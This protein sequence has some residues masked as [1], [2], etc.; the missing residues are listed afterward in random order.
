MAKT[1]RCKNKTTAKAMA[2]RLRGKGLKVSM[3]KNKKG[4]SVSA[5]R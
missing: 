2:K 1:H 5:W 3:A 4:W